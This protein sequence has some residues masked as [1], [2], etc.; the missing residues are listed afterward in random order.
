MHLV[1]IHDAKSLLKQNNKFFL[2]N[3]IIDSMLILGN[4]KQKIIKII[5]KQINLFVFKHKYS[6]KRVIRFWH[7]TKNLFSN[8]YKMMRHYYKGI[9]E[10]NGEV[11]FKICEQV[12]NISCQKTK[13][14]GLMK[15]VNHDFTFDSQQLCLSQFIRQLIN[16]LE[17]RDWLINNIE[18]AILTQGTYIIG[19]TEADYEIEPQQ[20][21]KYIQILWIIMSRMEII[22]LNMNHKILGARKITKLCLKNCILRRQFQ[23]DLFIQR[24]VVLSVQYVNHI[25][26]L[27]QEAN[28]EIIQIDLQQEQNIFIQLQNQNFLEANW[29]NQYVLIGLLNHWPNQ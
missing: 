17:Q 9:I 18:S 20:L 24:V 22:E 3:R 25:Q 5:E 6:I 10:A 23:I 21:S 13:G 11:Q 2:R 7:T 16:I 28:N 19:I 4:Q 27:L 14:Q 1:I 8:L 26:Q 12:Q 15:N 29:E